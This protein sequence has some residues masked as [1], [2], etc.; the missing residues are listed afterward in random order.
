MQ[1]SEAHQ[2]NIFYSTSN[3]IPVMW[4][5]LYRCMSFAYQQ[6]YCGITTQ[7]TLISK[8]KLYFSLLVIM[9]DIQKSVLL[10]ARRS[11]SESINRNYQFRKYT[12]GSLVQL[13]A[14]NYV[15]FSLFK[16]ISQNMKITKVRGP[17]GVIMVFQHKY[18]L[19][20]TFFGIPWAQLAATVCP[21]C[22][23]RSKK[24]S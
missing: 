16:L 23:R 3:T 20:M 5:F 8:V 1:F 19:T 7:E 17:C 13:T 10:L 11:D 22:Y 14:M 24:A 15:Q 21:R 12:A 6:L 18:P 9:P 2:F 4:H